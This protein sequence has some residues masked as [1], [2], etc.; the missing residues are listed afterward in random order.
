MGF[1]WYARF[2]DGS[3]NLEDDKHSG[4]P[5]TIRTPNVIETVWE[6]SSTD[7]RM[8]EEELDVSRETLHRVL[9][10]DFGKQKFSTL[11]ILHCLTDEQKALRL[12]A[13]QQ[14]I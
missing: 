8:M 3:E 1:E 2:W 7:H 10:G 9:V 6:L 14:F 4:R 11:F 12:K 5:T 13:C